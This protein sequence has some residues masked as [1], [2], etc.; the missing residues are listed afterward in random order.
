MKNFKRLLTVVL[1]VAVIL[2]AFA[3][4]ALAADGDA[5][6]S[7]TT[8]TFDFEEYDD[9]HVFS[10]VKPKDGRWVI[11]AAD[12]GNKYVVAEWTDD[13]G[14][15]TVDNW[16]IS[17]S[18]NSNP[19]L[20]GVLNN[21]AMSID[22]DIKSSSGS[23][24]AVSIRPDLYGGLSTGYRLSQGKSTYLSNVTELTGST[25]WN[26]ITFVYRHMGDGLFV[27]NIYVNGVLSAHSTSINYTTS[28]FSA[29]NANNTA[30]G[31]TNWPSLFDENGDAKYSNLH[32]QICSFYGSAA[33][34]DIYYDNIKF[35][36]HP[37]GIDNAAIAS[38]I[39]NDDYKM[40]YGETEAKIGDVYYDDVNEAFAK[41]ADGDKLALYT[42]VGAVILNKAI[43]VDANKYENGVATGELYDITVRSDAGYIVSYAD[44]VY[45]LTKSD[46]NVTVV[47]DPDCGQDACDCYGEGVGHDQTYSI[48]VPVGVVPEF[49]PTIK[50]SS[51]DGVVTEFIG[52]SYEKGGE[53]VEFSA[54]TEEQA[55]L[56]VLNLYPVYNVTR[57]SGRLVDGNRN[58]TM[59]FEHQFGEMLTA[60]LSITRPLR[61][62]QIP[63]SP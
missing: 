40:P 46:K 13:E 32:I 18:F 34:R 42:D 39:Y 1:S 51:A 7:V 59:F 3:V 15:S 17:T 60:T 44:G 61:S 20:Y 56:G 9:K 43:T 54:V 27:T 38:Y 36:I 12:N 41:A 57:Y 48:I 37:E 5:P 53:A 23:F 49:I 24:N 19:T 58:V 30:A 21:P 29:N 55:S 35:S 31:I 45:T 2:T 6:V 4:V 8:R 62:P 28:N 11:A 14:T 33:G 47:F 16:D 10:D 22:F 50:S 52:W 63:I 25:E 26:H